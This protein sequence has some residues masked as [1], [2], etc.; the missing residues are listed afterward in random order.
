MSLTIATHNILN[1]FSDEAQ[2]PAY[3]ANI[4]RIDADVVTLPEAYGEFETDYLEAAL[5]ECRGLGYQAVHCAYQDAD[6]RQDRH[7]LVVLSRV[8]ADLEV[9]RCATRNMIAGSLEDPDTQASVT[10]I[11]GHFDDRLIETKLGQLESMLTTTIP[12]EGPVVMAVDSNDFHRRDPRARLLRI[13]APAF[14][15]LKEGEPVF[16][17]KTALVDLPA[18][19]GSVGRRAARMA[20]GRLLQ[21]L[22]FH[23]FHDAAPDYKPT[24]TIANWPCAQLDHILTRDCP[25]VE[26]E[27]VPERAGSDH[28]PIKAKI[29]S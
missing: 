26:F 13:F 18:R 10:Y 19:V 5:D 2:W 14:N 4:A 7:G 12:L 15:L 28:F 23:G 27:V 20:E 25:V 24:F 16:G 3:V 29:S 6:S 22:E 21:A 11:G 1:G 8:K 9:V 17:K